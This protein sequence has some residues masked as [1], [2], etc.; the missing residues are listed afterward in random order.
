MIFDKLSYI[1]NCIYNTVGFLNVC[2]GSRSGMDYR[3]EDDLVSYTGETQRLFVTSKGKTI[4][5]K[6]SFNTMM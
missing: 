4:F 5:Q 6:M 3:S 2:T 1:D